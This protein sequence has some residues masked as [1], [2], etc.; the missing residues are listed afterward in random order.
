MEK[1][2]L[3]FKKYIDTMTGQVKHLLAGAPET[4]KIMEAFLKTREISR[5][6]IL[7]ILKA[8]LDHT[9]DLEEFRNVNDLWP[10]PHAMKDTVHS[11][12]CR[13]AGNVTLKAGNNLKALK[14]YNQAVLTAEHPDEKGRFV[15][16]RFVEGCLVES[17]EDGQKMKAVGKGV[18]ELEDQNLA[19]ALA[20][21]SV[22]LAKLGKWDQTVQGMYSYTQ[23]FL[24][25]YNSQKV[26]RKI[27]LGKRSSFLLF[28]N[29]KLIFFIMLRLIF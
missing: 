10:K 1:E 7:T 14:L 26:C 17:K 24:T 29:K 8:C 13:E 28:L 9:S 19:L 12:R 15:E 11:S 18:D 4:G 22:V 23:V 27:K 5:P 2:E 25:A 3:F 6:E 20:N 16:G 21:R